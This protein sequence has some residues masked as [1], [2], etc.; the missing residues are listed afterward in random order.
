MQPTVCARAALAFLCAFRYSAPVVRPAV[1]ASCIRLPAGSG[2]VLSLLPWHCCCWLQRWRA[3]GSL[4]GIAVDVN[5]TVP[6]TLPNIT[7]PR[8]PLTLAAK[9]CDCWGRRGQCLRHQLVCQ[10]EHRTSVI[11]TVLAVVWLSESRVV[12]GLC[13][14]LMPVLLRSYPPSAIYIAGCQPQGGGPGHVG[15]CP[16][17]GDQGPGGCQLCQ[18]GVPHA[19]R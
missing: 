1:P 12:V 2:S 3:A 13:I 4:A 6:S 15:Q 18:P 5:F 9:V 19:K 16:Q 17:C 14:R 8:I 7:I 11:A 10:A